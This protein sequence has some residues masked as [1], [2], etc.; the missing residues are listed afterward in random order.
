MF[1]A[2]PGVKLVALFSPEHGIGGE[3]DAAVANATDAATGLPIYSLY[4]ETRR[5]TDEMLHG[6][7]ILVFDIQDAG[8]RFYTYITT[9]AY[10]MEAGRKTPYSVLSFSTGPILSAGK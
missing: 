4:G 3:A 8:V 1:A 6:I 7:D 2:P 5:P 10:C 9:M